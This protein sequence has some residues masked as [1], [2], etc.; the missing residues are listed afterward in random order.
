VPA[1]DL[2]RAQEL[3]AAG[4]V[5]LGYKNTIFRVT[6]VL[7]EECGVADPQLDNKARKLILGV[8]GR[9]TVQNLSKKPWPAQGERP[10]MDEYGACDE[11]GRSW[12][13]KFF[14]EGECVVLCSFHR[15]EHDIQTVGGRVPK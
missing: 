4:G 3:S 6:E 8:I 12:Y 9:L 14:I 15:P 2:K 1:Y 13:V 11:Q 10:A 7:A 5:R